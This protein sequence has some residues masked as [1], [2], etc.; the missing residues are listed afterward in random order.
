MMRRISAS[1]GKDNYKI[2]GEA[3]FCGDDVSFSFVGGTHPHIGAVSLA[4][5]EPERDSA[6]VSTI[7]V[8]THRDDQLASGCAKAASAALKCTVTVSVGIHIEHATAQ[9]LE[10]LAGNFD[11]C[12]NLLMRK[13]YLERGK[14]E[15]IGT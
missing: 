2:T 6:T 12:C 10:L 9:E 3:V 11:Q 7:A 5:Y 4:V 13:I 1:F 8:Y 14:S 15:S